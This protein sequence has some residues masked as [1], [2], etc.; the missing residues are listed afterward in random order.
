MRRLAL[1]FLLSVTAA[2]TAAAAAVPVDIDTA[3]TVYQAA[4]IRDQVRASLTSMPGKMRTMFATDSAEKLSDSYLAAVSAAA[5]R[6]FRI[7]IFEPPAL[8][9]LAADLDAATVAKSTAF[10]DSDLGRRMV[11]ADVAIAELDEPTIAKIMDGALS[12]P[13]DPKRDALLDQIEAAT[14]STDSAVD[15]YLGIGRALAVGTAIGS[16]MDPVA[17]DL[18]ASKAAD[19]GARTDLANS[20]H[21]PLRRY[22]AYGYRDLSEADLKR[23]LKFLDSAAGRRY[24]LAYNAAMSAGFGA[25]AKRCGE[26]IGDRWRE[27]AQVQLAQPAQP[28]PQDSPV[29][30]EQPP[31]D[32]PM[33]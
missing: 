15:I 9:A 1:L 20:L 24:V 26:Q 29:A 11:A 5:E 28:A 23:L 7:D 12:A 30:P 22:I 32:A 25:M 14:R 18:R 3:A 8:A 6:G 4:A 13:S 19:A 17:A 21:A 33:H 10:L 16:G 2:A 31:P 27:L